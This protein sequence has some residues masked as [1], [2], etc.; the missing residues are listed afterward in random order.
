MGDLKARIGKSNNADNVI[1]I[2]REASCNRNGNLRIELLQNCNLMTCNWRTK[3]NDPQW[4][5]VH[6]RLGH[7]SI[8][9]YII[10]DKALMKEVI[11]LSFCR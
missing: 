1:G 8:V 6:S 7:R 3:L 2:F 4:T 10:T 11:E 9:N 5:R